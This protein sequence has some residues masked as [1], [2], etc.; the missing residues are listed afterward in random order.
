MS[1]M[2][3]EKCVVLLTMCQFDEYNRHKKKKLKMSTFCAFIDFPKAYDFI[4]RV[5]LWKKL[6]DICT[7]GN[8]L[9]AMKSL[10]KPVSSCTGC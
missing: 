10:Y 1:K 4:D 6:S 2:V 8:M 7:S 9:L 5:K 3:L